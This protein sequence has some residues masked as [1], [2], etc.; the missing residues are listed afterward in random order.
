MSPDAGITKTQE[1]VYEMKVGDVMSRDVITVESKDC[2]ATGSPA[3][4]SWRRDGW[5]A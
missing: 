5:R 3:C 1:M 2:A 4:P